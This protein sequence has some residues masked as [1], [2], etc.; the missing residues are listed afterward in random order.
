MSLNRLS[1]AANHY[2]RA[3]ELKPADYELVI[4]VAT[5]LRQ[6]NRKTE[7]E[8]WYRKAVKMKPFVSYR[9]EVILNFHNE[10]NFK[11]NV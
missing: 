2:I 1:E 7:A 3:A 4:T 11:I 8:Y 9:L 6:A 5:V 10:N